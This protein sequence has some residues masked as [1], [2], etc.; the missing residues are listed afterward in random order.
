[1]EAR[2]LQPSNA[3]YAKMVA[4]IHRSAGRYP[5]ALEMSEQAAELQPGNP[6][7]ALEA[8]QA[9]VRVIAGR[10]NLGRAIRWYDEVARIDPLGIGPEEAA[11]FFEAIGRHGRAEEIR[12]RRAVGP[13]SGG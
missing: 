1:E 8:A 6:Q 9:A 12:Y 13:G 11:D 3:I 10:D 4:A 5:E 7:L 2:R